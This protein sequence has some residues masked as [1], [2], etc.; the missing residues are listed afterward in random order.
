MESSFHTSLC[1]VGAKFRFTTCILHD[2]AR[3]WWCEVVYGLKHDVVKSLS[4]E[5][6]VT[7]FVREFMLTIEVQHLAW[8]YLMLE[9]TSETIVDIATKIRERALFCPQYVAIEE[10]RKTRYH[11]M[12]R[13]EIRE[14]MNISSDLFWLSGGSEG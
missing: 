12:L 1:P 13:A 3:D 4:C 6:L 8:E 14:L 7:R 11:D 10:T 5:D 9:K 2:R